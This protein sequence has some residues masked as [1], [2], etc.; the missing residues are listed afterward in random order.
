MALTLT[1]EDILMV[2]KLARLEAA[3]V[4][5]RS[6]LNPTTGRF[7]GGLNGASQNGPFDA[8]DAAHGG[9]PFA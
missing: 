3:A 8:L 2:R 4:A 9:N 6:A 5:G 1:P 7:P